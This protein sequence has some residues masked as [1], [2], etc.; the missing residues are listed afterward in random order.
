MPCMVNL[1]LQGIAFVSFVG[2]AP[3]QS[4]LTQVNFFYS[5]FDL[6]IELTALQITR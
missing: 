5:C 4:C 1:I 3:L 2:T 6:M